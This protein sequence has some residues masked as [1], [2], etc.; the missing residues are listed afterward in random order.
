MQKPLLLL[1][2]TVAA[3][4]LIALTLVTQFSRIPADAA[5][6]TFV[7]WAIEAWAASAIAYSLLWQ[8]MRSRDGLILRLH[9]GAHVFGVLST[10]LATAAVRMGVVVVFGGRAALDP[11]GGLQIFLFLVVPS[12]VAFAVIGSAMIRMRST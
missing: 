6:T 2:L 9:S 7:H 11:E 3:V 10:M 8:A 5:W 1:G 4:S 12:A